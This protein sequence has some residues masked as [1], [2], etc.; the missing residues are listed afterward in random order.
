M[1]CCDFDQADSQTQPDRYAYTQTD[2]EQRCDP[3][4][5][6]GRGGQTNDERSA[7][8]IRY[9]V[10]A[11]HNYDPT[12]SHGLIVV[13]APAG[14]SAL[15]T[16]RLM[17]ITRQATG[18][19]FI[20]AYADHATLGLT[21]VRELATIPRR[22]G[23]KWCVDATR[24]FLT[25]HSDGGTVSHLAAVLP[26]SRNLTSGI[27][28]SAAGVVADDL[29]TYGCRQPMP[30][31]IMHSKNDTLFAGFGAQT[32]QWWAQCNRCDI[33]RTEPLPNGCTA[34]QG[35]V[36]N[37]PTWYCEG[38]GRHGAWPNRNATI[39]EFFRKQTN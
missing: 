6:S 28:P 36:V 23:D 14:A 27:A 15:Q 24:I 32:A 7:K 35:C 37:A 18:A 16:E 4:I 34:Y 12:H 3:A 5:K 17:G 2:R 8:G 20:V 22:V 13:F 19:G 33:A 9:N 38:D 25:G 39:I 11:P 21:A 10:R 29:R 31:L 26:E 1:A 30:V